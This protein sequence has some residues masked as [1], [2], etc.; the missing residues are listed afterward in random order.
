LVFEKGKEVIPV[1]EVD[2]PGFLG[3]SVMIYDVFSGNCLIE[4]L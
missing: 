1:C 4:D 3:D 2:S